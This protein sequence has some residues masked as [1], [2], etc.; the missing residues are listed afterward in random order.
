MAISRQGY[1]RVLVTGAGGFI[2]GHLVRE[3]IERGTEVRAVDCKPL[4]HWFQLHDGADNRVL[5]LS[6]RETG[7]EAVAGVS[8]VYNL[9]A[10]M[11]A[12][13]SSRATRLS[14]CSRS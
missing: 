6:L 9:S 7:A 2:G 10:D 5:D 12:W 4:E 13:A 3:L 8:D 14:A 1:R 11:G